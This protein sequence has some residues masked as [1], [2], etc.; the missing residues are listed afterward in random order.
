MSQDTVTRPVGV[1]ELRRAWHALQQGQFRARPTAPPRPDHDAEGGCAPRWDPAEPVLPVVGCIGQAG[2]TTL[3]LAIATV[4]EATRLIECG[5][6]TA[7][8]L[9]AAATAELGRDERWTLGRR[10]R[11]WLARV[12]EVLL[13]PS[14]TPLPGE[15][16]QQVSLS[17]LDVAWEV[18]QVMACDGWI[19]HQLLAAPTPVLV[20][21]PTVPGLRRLEI[22]LSLLPADQPVIAMTGAPARRWP[23]QL[24]G[25][26]GP[27]TAAALAD[28]RLVNIP[29]DKSLAIRGVSSSP[30]PTSLLQAAETL[31]QHTAVRNHHQKGQQS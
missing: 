9:A 11:V 28:Q 2:A 21:S 19:R 5:T 1:D 10:D 26:I 27:L 15:L 4:A 7:S 12:S 25:S 17:V 14:E 13:D 3:A 8:G 24:T 20:T 6:A 18:G 16:A 22:A 23:A 30:L 29:T 31:L